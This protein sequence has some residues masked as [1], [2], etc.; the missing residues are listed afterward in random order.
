VYE[1][2]I[3]YRI[4]RGCFWTYYCSL[5]DPYCHI[6]RHD[7]QKE[8]RFAGWML[9]SSAVWIT[10]SVPIAGTFNLLILYTPAILL[11]G[12]AA[13]LSFKEPAEEPLNEND[14]P[15]S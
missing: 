12:I 9:L 6:Q 7:A 11:L 15:G 13:L 8:T 4:Y 5:C 1:K 2:A 3:S 10:L 14:E